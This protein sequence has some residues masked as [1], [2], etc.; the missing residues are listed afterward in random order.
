MPDLATLRWANDLL[1]A[2]AL[3]FER[4]GDA[5]TLRFEEPALPVVF[6]LL[7]AL[8][9]A[10][11]LIWPARASITPLLVPPTAMSNA[12]TWNTSAFEIATVAGPALGGVLIAAAGTGSVYALGAVLEVEV[13][14]T[15]EDGSRLRLQLSSDGTRQGEG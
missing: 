5:A 9:C 2:T 3:L 7:L 14:L 11:I 12:I 8:A 4:S 1:R 15:G 6:L 10:R 13:E